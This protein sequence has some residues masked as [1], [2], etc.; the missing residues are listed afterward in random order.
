MRARTP[1]V[2]LAVLAV[3]ACATP[4]VSVPTFVAPAAPL[5]PP[6][7]ATP[8]APPPPV[9]RS[10][11]V[12]TAPN[13]SRGELGVLARYPGFRHVDAVAGTLVLWDCDDAH[14]FML[15]ILDADLLHGR[16]VATGQ[17]C[18][19]AT[20][21]DDLLVVGS[22]AAAGARGVAVHIPSGVVE[23]YFPTDGGQ[24]HEPDATRKSGR[25]VIGKT[26]YRS[27]LRMDEQL[28]EIL[29]TAD[30]GMP[31]GVAAF[32]AE[33]KHRTWHA[34]RGVTSAP[35]ASEGTLVVRM[36]D[37]LAELDP[38]TGEVLWEHGAPG[39]APDLVS[40]SVNGADG[41]AILEC[42]KTP[43][44]EWRAPQELGLVLYAR[45]APAD[46]PW[47]G[48]VFGTVTDIGKGHG[49][50]Y[51]NLRVMA[52][53]QQTKTDAHGKY[54]LTLTTRGTITVD[55][56]V[57]LGAGS[58]P[59]TEMVLVT[60]GHGDYKIDLRVGYFNQACR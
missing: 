8:S 14:H 41:F 47:T 46:P 32:D 26:V 28:E 17:G 29:D 4:V 34:L 6:A 33:T 12:L 49:R 38:R 43:S 2:H 48:K 13:P 1:L 51:K 37:S 10:R 18:S 9:A 25:L 21:V 22:T 35:A 11:P 54:E 27:P 59:D 23:P 55:T 39:N 42:E 40:F 5:A 3:A 15:R 45:G 7:S 20:V 57:G 53:T 52:G 58:S 31:D 36:P 56:E 50:P 24:R 19:S 16:D 44:C 30:Y 60:P